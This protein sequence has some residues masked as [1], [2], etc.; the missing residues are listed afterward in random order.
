MLAVTFLQVN[1]T[2]IPP[3]IGHRVLGLVT[4]GHDGLR[5]LADFANSGK[6]LLPGLDAETRHLLTNFCQT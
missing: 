2:R 3:E 4:A 5:L 1:S 6:D